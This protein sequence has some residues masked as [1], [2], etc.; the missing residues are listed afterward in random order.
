MFSN[1]MNLKQIKNG[2]LN[3]NEIKIILIALAY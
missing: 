3:T 2:T 1:K